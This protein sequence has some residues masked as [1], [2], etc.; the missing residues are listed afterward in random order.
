MAGLSCSVLP[1]AR[2]VPAVSGPTRLLVGIVEGLRR[3]GATIKRL[4]DRRREIHWAPSDELHP[5][6]PA[7]CVITKASAVES[8]TGGPCYYMVSGRR[9][10]T[11]VSPDTEIGRFVAKQFAEPLECLAMRTGVPGLRLS[12]G[13]GR[14]AAG[15]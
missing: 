3:W 8:W 10:A 5:L 9:V 4:G 11:A 6:S 15:L 13:R 12:G 2:L 1:R 14:N 7:R